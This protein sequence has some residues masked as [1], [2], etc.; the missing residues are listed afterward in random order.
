M[1]NLFG[2]SYLKVQLLNHLDQL[3]ILY[4]ST[5]V[6]TL[7][8]SETYTC[9]FRTP[10]KNIWSNKSSFERL[11]IIVE[12]ITWYMLKSE[13]ITSKL[14]EKIIQFY[15]HNKQ[16]KLIA[17]RS[18]GLIIIIQSPLIL[19][20]IQPKPTSQMVIQ[21]WVSCDIGKKNHLISKINKI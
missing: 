14:V 15:K 7:Q 8:H 4:E 19:W 2:L 11:Q 10:Q 18:L 12:L 1:T 3:N 9:D 13:E 16:Y 17:Y 5:I 21:T 6:Q 20:L